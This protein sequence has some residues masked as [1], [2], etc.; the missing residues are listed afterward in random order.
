M[1][2]TQLHCHLS[3]CIRDGC[4]INEQSDRKCRIYNCEKN[5]GKGRTL[6]HM[7]KERWKNYKSFDLPKKQ[8]LPNGIVK[9]CK[10]HGELKKEQ[11][12]RHVKGNY[13]CLQCKKIYRQ[14]NKEKI[15]EY[16]LKTRLRRQNWIKQDRLENPEKHK[17]Y[18]KKYY[19]IN[20]EEWNDKK[21]TKKYKIT[22]DQYKKMIIDSENKCEICK[23]EETRKIG[24]REKT[25]RLALDHDHKTLKIRGIL[26]SKCN[27]MLDK[28]NDSIEILENAIK[29]LKK[30][31]KEA[32]NG[33]AWSKQ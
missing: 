13:Y 24:K 22:L 23:Q 15:K 27:L 29:Y 21:I 1:D 5:A 17:E 32:E 31:S 14:K 25:C 20:G 16:N 6:C 9:I 26:C 11:T 30:H 33:C 2:L 3:G 12:T 18:G 19:S 7:H 10:I 28:C 4:P 8:K